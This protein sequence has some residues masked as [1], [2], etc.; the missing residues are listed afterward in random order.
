[1][2]ALLA[3]KAYNITVLSRDASR[4]KDLPAN[5]KAVTVDYLSVSQLTKAFKGQDAVVSTVSGTVVW[6][7]QKPMVDAAIA[8]GVKVFIPS[9]FGGMIGDPRSRNLIGHEPTFLIREYLASKCGGYGKPGD[10]S[11]KN[12]TWTAVVCGAPFELI[13]N[14]PFVV[15]FQN[16]AAQLYDGG[17]VKFSGTAY[18]TIGASVVGVLRNHAAVA[19]RDVFVH[20]MP[21]TQ[22]MVLAMA[23]RAEKEVLGRDFE[24]TITQMDSQ[25]ELKKGLQDVERMQHEDVID[26]LR[27]GA[28]AATLRAAWF[29]GNYQNLYDKVDN[30]ILGLP[31]PASTEEDVYQMVVKRVKGESAGLSQ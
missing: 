7:A 13:L 14:W 24:W 9:C 30:H 27:A 25:K 16:H 8:A 22:N 19:N 18:Q 5:V 4:H 21:V 20:G 11:G 3:A 12:M 29:S 23:Q 17:D 31:E 15:D 28:V 1:M 6:D 10:G 26:Q 2:D